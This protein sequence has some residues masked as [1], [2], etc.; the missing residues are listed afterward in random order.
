MSV[1]AE[2]F[3]EIERNVNV[4][5]YRRSARDVLLYRRSARDVPIRYSC[6]RGDLVYYFMVS[7]LRA[8]A[9]DNSV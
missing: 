6:R 2:A 7:E 3:A 8:Y 9:G 5:L 4:L 1:G